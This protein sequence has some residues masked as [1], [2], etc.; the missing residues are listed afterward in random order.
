MANIVRWNP[1]RDMIQMREAMD[2]A[3][4]ENY[5]G[6]ESRTNFSLPIDAYATEEALVL[7]ADVPGLKPED[8]Q[9]TLEGDTLT[10]RG[11]YQTNKEQSGNG[12]NFLMR[13]RIYGKF[14]RTLTINTPIDPAKVEA[15][16]ENGVLTLTLP[17]TEAVKP[18]QISVKASN[19]NK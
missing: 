13:E 5:F 12:K 17:K 2:R 9:V 19:G 16:F 15:T 14:E 1:V 10:I 7:K 8:I 11:E 18:R 3:F 4:G 6:R